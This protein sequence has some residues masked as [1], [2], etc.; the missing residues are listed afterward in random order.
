MKCILIATSINNNNTSQ[1]QDTSS[2]NT[3]TD[4]ADV[5]SMKQ[6]EQA[7]FID[8]RSHVVETG[9]IQPVSNNVSRVP[10]S[11]GETQ[12]DVKDLLRQEIKYG[13]FLWDINNGQGAELYSINVPEIFNSLS[14]I[15]KLQFNTF[16]FYRFNPTL[17][18]QVNT[19]KFNSGRLMVVW[20]PLSSMSPDPTA[21]NRATT[22]T[23]H[24]CQCSGFPNV[25]IDAKDS[26]SAFI[27]IPFEHIISYFSASSNPVDTTLPLGTIRI[28]CM[29]Q[30]TAPDD[31]SSSVSVNVYLKCEDIEFHVPTRPHNVSFQA[32]GPMD[33]IKSTLST[34]K[35][36]LNN[37]KTGNFSGAASG[38][39]GLLKSFSLDK[40]AKPEAKIGNCLATVDPMAHMKG[41]VDTPRL[42]ATAVGGYL[43]ESFTKAPPAELMINEIISK[44]TFV[45]S[46]KWRADQ[47]ENTVLVTIPVT[48]NLRTYSEQ[49]SYKNTLFEYPALGQTYLTNQ[50]RHYPSYVGVFSNMFEYWSGSLDYRFDVVSTSFHTGRLMF[51]FEPCVAPDPIDPSISDN[52]FSNSPYQMFDLH[53]SASTSFKTN[54]VSSTPRKRCDMP[55][56]G[57]KI[58][59]NTVLGYLRVIVT[60]RLVAPERITQ[61]VDVNCWISAGEDFRFT[62]P[63]LNNNVM[64]TTDYDKI[65]VSPG[66]FN[67]EAEGPELPTESDISS[68][69]SDPKNYP[70]LVKGNP[71]IPNADP[72]GEEVN[73]VLDL[74]RR[75]CRTHE[76]AII[77][78]RQP[79]SNTVMGYGEYSIVTTP[80]AGQNTDI[81]T[82]DSLSFMKFLSGM[83][84]FW[85][86]SLRYQ[87]L[88]FVDR[89]QNM[90]HTL[91]FVPDFTTNLSTEGTESAT[92]TAALVNSS[93]PSII[94]NSSQDSSMQVEVPFYSKFNQC[95]ITPKDTS[96]MDQVY[97]DS[98][99][100]GK[101][102]HRF[103]LPDETT[104]LPSKTLYIILNSSIGD[105]FKYRFLV[106][107]PILLCNGISA[108]S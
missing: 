13:S 6:Q 43:E 69:T 53:E 15:H 65:A 105:D 101:L 56:T 89:T 32:E 74:A 20:D 75:Y 8:E 82:I 97:Y 50:F 48:P 17:R 37:V 84:V 78:S 79:F 95:A 45:G 41:V 68:R 46:F 106:A 61:E 55:L 30:L 57:V 71:M 26:N 58:D 54:F 3:T 86:G 67:F 4:V 59:D 72:F 5:L 91:T 92:S 31:A 62:V 63:R 14:S 21:Y 22:H 66:A 28:M 100:T 64:L 33:S 73:S 107:P 52:A 12:W 49:W 88:P 103:M 93:Y 70:G 24:L 34:G 96:G 29:N 16:Q 18:V 42:A 98:F 9:Y 47:P 44:P 40:P 94:W 7:T 104:T 80:A 38:L 76:I 51:T 1:P 35:G 11:M 99:F 60:S 85:S 87:I 27:T 19:T 25:Q 108:F 83:Y 39:S 102:V 90:L 81:K 36:I 77:L 2:Q 23:N 10:N